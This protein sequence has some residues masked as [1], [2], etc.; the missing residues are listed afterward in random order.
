MEEHQEHT[1]RTPR[2][3][4]KLHFYYPKDVAANLQQ[5]YKRKFGREQERVRRNLGSMKLQ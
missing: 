3:P 1:M 2:D 5:D 4:P